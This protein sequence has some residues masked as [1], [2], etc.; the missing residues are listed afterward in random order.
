MPVDLVGETLRVE[1][2]VSG[3][4]PDGQEG[5]ELVSKREQWLC[6]RGTTSSMAVTRGEPATG[7][8]FLVTPRY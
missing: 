6:S 5:V 2:S 4:V 7:F 3:P 8:R 1:A